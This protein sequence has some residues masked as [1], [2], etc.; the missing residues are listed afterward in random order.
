MA[1]LLWFFAFYA[2]NLTLWAS[3]LLKFVIHV[4]N[5]QLSDKFDN[6]WKIIKNGQFIAIFRILRQ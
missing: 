2:Y 5:K 3:I 4:T 1:D 6:G